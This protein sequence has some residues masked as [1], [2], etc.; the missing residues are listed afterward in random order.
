MKEIL[1]VK[2]INNY[3][4]NNIN[5][6][7]EEGTIT[8]IIGKSG[9]GK[10]TIA[11]ILSKIENFKFGLIELKYKNDYLN[12]AEIS[13]KNFYSYLQIVFQ[14]PYSS[15]NPQRTIFESLKVPCKNLLNLKNDECRE[16]CTSMLSLVGL[17]DI[18][19][20][21]YPN[22]LSGGQLQRINIARALI[23]NPKILILDEPLSA[24]DISVQSQ[25]INLLLELN[26]TQKITMIFISHDL[27]VVRHLSDYIY[28]VDTG[29]IIE[30][31]KMYDIFHNPIKDLTKLMVDNY[32]SI[33][34]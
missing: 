9:G 3:I 16:K 25:I 19:L 32:N 30:H 24:L 27:H 14:D 12:I 15:L 8:S 23:P 20:D 17:N 7:I 28:V 1:R 33:K 5:L 31:G 18:V 2:N 6:D 10:S 13:N 4:L 29:S 34:I 22:Q 21:M 26:K 11:K